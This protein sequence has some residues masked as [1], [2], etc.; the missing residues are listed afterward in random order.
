MTA[1]CISME[2]AEEATEGAASAEPPSAPSPS[3]AAA[4]DE[5][6]ARALEAVLFALS[7]GE[8][9]QRVA[10]LRSATGGEP[11]A[12]LCQRARLSIR[13][14]AEV[15]RGVD[16]R[17]NHFTTHHDPHVYTARLGDVLRALRRGII[18]QGLPDPLQG[19]TEE[20]CLATQPRLG[21]FEVWALVISPRGALPP[22][23]L[24]SKLNTSLFPRGDSCLRR[25]KTVLGLAPSS[26]SAPS[27]AP[28][29]SAEGRGSRA[30]PTMHRARSARSVSSLGSAGGSSTLLSADAS[31]HSPPRC[32][33]T[34]WHHR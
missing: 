19:R 14:Y 34:V 20:A 5:A 24:H 3:P 11:I 21:A 12:N 29:A 31:H 10:T 17:W 26:P 25:L 16:G 6:Q 23:L 28:F 2:L 18:M 15:D 32:A 9:V 4:E 13:V 8:F 1:P 30:A 7:R 27:S 33:P 22:I